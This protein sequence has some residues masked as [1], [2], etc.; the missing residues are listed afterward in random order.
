[1]ITLPEV[2]RKKPGSGVYKTDKKG[3]VLRGQKK[4]VTY[5]SIFKRVF[6]E[7]RGQAVHYFPWGRRK[8]GSLQI[9]FSIFIGGISTYFM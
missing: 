8:E 5:T 9:A 6:E 4:I 3:F 7:G 2:G 1:M